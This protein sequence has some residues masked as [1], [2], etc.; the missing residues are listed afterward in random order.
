[1]GGGI[2]LLAG[3]SR[4]SEVT[5]KLPPQNNT[6]YD[7]SQES[8]FTDIKTPVEEDIEIK[9]EKDPQIDMFEVIPESLEYTDDA[10]VIK[11]ISNIKALEKVFLDKQFKTTK[12]STAKEAAE[13]F[14]NQA[15]KNSKYKGDLNEIFEIIPAI[16]KDGKQ[17]YKLKKREGGV[18]GYEIIPAIDKDGKQIYKLRS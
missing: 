14:L 16:D 4:Y 8:I 15:N 1:M 5:P 12:N 7:T 10:D 6:E 11:N 3:D 13:K 17:I 18:Y 9:K 2:S